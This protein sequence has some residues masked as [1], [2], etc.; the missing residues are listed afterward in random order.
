MKRPIPRHL[1]MGA[2]LM[3][4]TGVW[5]QSASARQH[6]RE[7]MGQGMVAAQCTAD[8]AKHCAGISHGQGR[9]RTCLEEHK[10][11]L[12]AGCKT[13]LESRGAHHGGRGQGAGQG[14]MMGHRARQGQ[15]K[16]GRMDRGHARGV[17][18]REKAFSL[19]D[20]RRIVDGRL[21]WYGLSR[22]KSGE[23]KEVGGNDVHVD[24]VTPKGEMVFRLRVNRRTGHTALID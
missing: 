2:I 4:A 17:F 5:Q 8:I 24:V 14:R 9:V 12:S 18:K 21:A 11:A 1:L 3:L 19:D 6:G 16:R 22:L 13:A 15:H 20:V 23:L 10:S 7:Q